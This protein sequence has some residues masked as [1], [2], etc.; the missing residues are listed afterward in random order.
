MGMTKYAHQYVCSHDKG[1]GK[2]VFPTDTLWR[3]CFSCVADLLPDVTPLSVVVT[4][5]QS[6]FD[7]SESTARRA[8]E[9]LVDAGRLAVTRK[10]KRWLISVK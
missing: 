9:R 4:K 10:G 5:M 2:N 7:W 6:K 3:C 1:P 8:V